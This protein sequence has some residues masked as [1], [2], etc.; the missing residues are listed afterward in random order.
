MNH[1]AAPAWSPHSLRARRT[2]QHT[3][4]HLL[5]H[6]PPTP[7]LCHLLPALGADLASGV[8]KPSRRPGAS[9]PGPIPTVGDVGVNSRHAR[10][11]PLLSLSIAPSVRRC[12]L[13]N[14]S[15]P[16]PP[17]FPPLSFGVLFWAL[18][19]RSPLRSWCSGSSSRRPPLSFGDSP[20]SFVFGGGPR[21]LLGECAIEAARLRNG[22]ALCY[23]QAAGGTARDAAGT[24]LCAPCPRRRPPTPAACS[25][26]GGGH[27]SVAAWRWPQGGDAGRDG[28]CE[29][30][31][32]AVTGVRWGGGQR[33][34]HRRWG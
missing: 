33:C 14:A 28:R 20:V 4:I 3:S 16:P 13:A 27:P 18:S 29:R 6:A 32:T 24:P 22:P 30:R 5:P 8:Y 11:I 21:G 19:S 9:P 34:G 7:P 23:G 2:V 1:D 31:R 26:G 15:P 12:H 10:S 25:C 17:R